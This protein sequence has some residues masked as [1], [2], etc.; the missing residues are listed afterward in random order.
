MRELLIRS[1][2]GFAW[3]G[4]LAL[5]AGADEPSSV[6]PMALPV[7]KANPGAAKRVL[8]VTGLDYPGHK[9]RATTPVLTAALAQDERLEIS[10]VEDA[11][12]LGS[13]ELARFDAIVLHYQNHQIPAPEG[14]LANLK[15]V[16]EAGKGL[17][18]VHFACGAF[19]DWGP[20]LVAPDFGLIA[21]RVWNPKL[22]GHDPRGPFQVRIV[23]RSHPITAGLA[24]FETDDELYT[25]LEGSV[26]IQVLA[27]A[28]S[29]VDG[30][31]YP[32]AFVLQPGKGRTFH[33]VL[34]HDPK[35]LE[36]PAVGQLFIRG[37]AWAVGLL[38]QAP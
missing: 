35:A 15:Q 5:P 29:K 31:D 38:P 19:I 9:W 28:T 1:I 26:P 23:D 6:L 7:V 36:F 37:T 8:I 27:A 2:V 17:V 12:F 4:L 30:K 34:G 16:V 25:C 18:L 10:V 13:P 32:I 24:D 3:L 11:R 20:R 14:A 22:R 21:G 33:C